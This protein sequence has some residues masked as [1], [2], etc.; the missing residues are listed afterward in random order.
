MKTLPSRLLPWLVLSV[1]LAPWALPA[2]SPPSATG[3]IEGRVLNAR[4]GEYLTGARI[5]VDGTDLEEFTNETGEFQLVGVPAGGAKLRV[6]YTGFEPLTETVNVAPG[7]TLRRD[8]TF[9]AS[10]GPT[11]GAAPDAPIQLEKFVVGVSREMEGSAF[12][13]NEQR[14]A[15][16]MKTVASAE[17]YGNVAEGN[18]AEFLKFLPGVAIEYT[19]GNARDISING[20]PSANVPVTV[21]GFN[22][23][24]AANRGTGRAV[25]SDMISINNLS[26]IEVAYSPTP[27]S[28][29]AALGGS[30]NM[31]PRSAFERVRPVFNAS[32]SL[33]MRDNARDF[34]SVPGPKPS[35]TPNV[36]PGFDFSWVAPVSRTF[37][38]TLSGGISTNYS[39]QDTVNLQW[40][41]TGQATNGN[42]F[43][44]T[45]PD[46]P[47]LT[48]FQVQD[49]PKVTTRRSV[50]ATIDYRFTA[51][52]RVSLGF[53]YSSFDGR[54]IVQNM[55]FNPVRVAVGA[56][57]PFFTH[58]SDGAGNV[59]MAHNERNR[60]NRT[61]LPTL[62]WRHEG[63]VWK[64]DAG[65]G[66]SEQSDYNRDAEQGFF[67]TVTVQRTGATVWFDDNFYLRPRTITV[68]DGGTGAVLDPTR[69]AN[70][71]LT[72]A[73]IQRDATRDLQRTAYGSVRRDFHLRVP[74]TLKA[75]IDLRE[76]V[77]NIR[78]GTRTYN[79]VGPD[80]R[81]TT[82]PAAGDDAAAPFLDPI[83]SQ[84]IM[85]YGFGQVEGVSCRKVWEHYVAHPNYFTVNEAT[86]YTAQVNNSKFIDERVSSAYLRGDVA[87]FER[88]LKLV[89]GVRAEQTNIH[90]EGPLSDPTRNVLRDASGKPILG[91]NGRPQPIT[92]D[93][94][95][96]AQLTT[97]DR[98][99]VTKKEYLRLFPSVNASYHLR[100]NLAVRAAYYESIGRPNLN[101][102][103]GGLTLPDTDSLPSVTNR[104]TAGNPGIKAWSARTRN[105]RLE[106]YFQKVGQ[107]SVG[108]FR[109]DI[110]DF[111]SD[112]V[113]P[114]T[115]EFLA[116]YGLPA[117]VYGAYDVVTQRNLGS[118]VR[119]EGVDLSY[120]QALTFLPPWARGVQVFANGSA[121]RVTGD[122]TADFAGYVPRTAS[123]G[124]SLTREKFNFRVNWNY[125]GRNRNAPIAAG[126]SIAPGTFNW[127]SKKLYVDVLGEYYFWRRVAFFMN[128]RNFTDS[129]ED[130][131]IY[132]PLT[133]PVARFR[134]RID[135][136]SLWTFG[137]KGTF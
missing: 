129:T 68:R 124:V 51:R 64:A 95:A 67:R 87:L 31:V 52:D 82:T 15:A 136:A 125:R 6:F 119:T 98:G 30:V 8:I 112:T 111:F 34:R 11:P 35:P 127:T 109:R 113:M 5:T 132:G 59:Q 18:G 20:V 44:H 91:S 99:S 16:N 33:L 92:T 94:L 7:A 1:S 57:S 77:R 41:G 62:V 130:T 106:Y 134:Q 39:P 107:V 25:Q 47:Y 48:Q 4:T 79:Y 118:T 86:A 29:G 133:P 101:Q 3:M 115:P 38:Y 14:F 71:A 61:Y 75:G 116:L 21:D 78:G 96:A 88:R 114:V 32:L 26:R 93:P 110:T 22:V 104:I 12:A 102:F 120:K 100:E 128:L 50:G 137:V 63:P 81:G 123:W 24:T 45:T 10:T 74:F 69:L 131:K 117:A 83:F 19:G 108:A 42:A 27:E 70:Y 85:P 46:Q 121:Q 76:A 54:F 89:G 53:Q 23:A 97:I 13:I 60:F 40:R 73:T 55:T 84:R 9:G 36:H 80:G 17:E 103:A 58:G 90:A 2:E 56:F 66:F 49:A 126:A 105:V 65:V 72:T 28:Q 135:Y 43:P 37:G 122:E